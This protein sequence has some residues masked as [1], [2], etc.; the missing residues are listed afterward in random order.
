VFG[1]GGFGEIGVGF[2]R[3]PA[4]TTKRKH[5][6]WRELGKVLH[7]WETGFQM[8]NATL[9]RGGRGGKQA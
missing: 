1:E 3:L 2:A 8:Q 7:R 4:R 9:E 5:Q 6:E